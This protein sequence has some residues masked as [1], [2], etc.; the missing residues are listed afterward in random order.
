MGNGR[1]CTACSLQQLLRV[2]AQALD[3]DVCCFDVAHLAV[4][5]ASI[6]VFSRPL[7]LRSPAAFFSHGLSLRCLAHAGLGLGS[8][9]TPS[10]SSSQT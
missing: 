4:G 5:F 6:I 9:M 1:S 10:L 3:G 2:M 8:Y 7:Q